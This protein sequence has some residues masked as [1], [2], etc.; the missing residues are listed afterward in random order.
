MYTKSYNRDYSLF[1]SWIYYIQNSDSKNLC[2]RTDLE[3]ENMIFHC[4]YSASNDDVK[5]IIYSSISSI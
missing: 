3:F 1:Q 4:S 5:E 2:S